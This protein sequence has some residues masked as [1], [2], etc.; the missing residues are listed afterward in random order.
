M[1]SRDPELA[2]RA[3]Y[4]SHVFADP[5]DPET[6]WVLNVNCLRSVDGGKNFHSVA[7]PHGDNHDLWIDPNDPLRMIEGN[8]GGGCVTF[9]GGETWSSLGNQPT[10]Q[11]YHVA[12]DTAYPYRIY[13]AQQDNT[14]LS[15]PSRTDTG[16]ITLGDCYT[17]G[18]GESGYIQV[19]PDN[20]DIVY[21]GSYSLLTRYDHKSRSARNVL[22]WPDNPMGH[23][24]EDLR[25]RFQWTFP[26]LIS[27][28]DPDVLYCAANV[29]FRSRDEGQN[30]QAISPDL[31]RADPATLGTSGGPITQDNTSVEYYATVFALAESPLAK[32][33]LWAGSDDGKIHVSADGGGAW[34]DVTPPEL[35]AGSQVSII[36]ASPH[37]ADA[38]YV[39]VTR[40]RMD[41]HRPLLL[42]T[43]DRG[44]TWQRID[45]GLPADETTRVVRADPARSGLLYAGTEKG[46]YVS[47]DDGAAWQP[48]R[49]NLPVV[50]VHDLVV[51]EGDLV[52]A[53]HGRSFWI[54]DDL[55][56]VREGGAT[57]PTAPIRL[58]TPRPTVLPRG[59]RLGPPLHDEP[60]LSYRPADA[61]T[62]TARIEGGDKP[63]RLLDAGENPP[64]GLVVQYYLAQAPAE[65][66]EVRLAFLDAQGHE[67]RCYT[68]RKAAAPK[69]KDG[70]EQPPT[71]SAKAGVNRFVWDCRHP[72]ASGLEGV[73]LW[74][75]NLLGPVVAPG[76]Y[77]VRLTAGGQTAEAA[78][79]LVPD[80]RIDV[81]KADLVEQ[82]AF[83]VTLRDQ[84]SRVHETV[85]R[86]R[87][88]RADLTTWRER[89]AGRPGAESATAGIA[90]LLDG[91]V[92]IEEA[93]IQPRIKVHEDPLNYPIRLN[94]KLA[95]LANAVSTAPCQPSLQAREVFAA[96]QD[97]AE[98]EIARLNELLA[99][100]LPEVNEELR[101]MD[102]AFV[103]DGAQAPQPVG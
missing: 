1:L 101:A 10:A 81:T 70:T 62:V 20:P 19:R 31:T 47:F 59:G 50:P 13:G 5:K 67:I 77:R 28:H 36:E 45:H 58:F 91:L 9:D 40:Y 69:V 41:D 6:V 7:T 97:E 78:F 94:N 37:E 96:L 85:A 49:G 68:S 14:T 79:E 33:L 34:H 44:R 92:P 87:R 15:V 63:A 8:D 23:A 11:F 30:W 74:A 2:Q 84:L 52:A 61:L 82:T 76:N 39:A 38:A 42:R 71:V 66:A 95:S 55:T 83:L 73:V 89:I 25:Y 18:G 26:I 80:P 57:A 46:V 102:L 22:P 98:R 17:V 4:Y 88:V 60:G 99:A 65:D 32:G 53:T 51:V 100:S 103:P 43:R 27:P 35:E 86:L 90:A 75:G 56:P 21:A 29:V 54:L 72:G 93:L 24:A 48:L 64:S 12:V 16:A 3:W